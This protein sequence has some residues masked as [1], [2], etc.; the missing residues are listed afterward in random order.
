M[1][2]IKFCGNRPTGS[3]EENFSRVLNIYGR[4]GHLGHVTKISRIKLQCHHLRRLHINFKLIGQAIVD[5]DGQTDGRLIRA[6]L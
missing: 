1:L 2:R 5:D 6:I 3:G 4:G